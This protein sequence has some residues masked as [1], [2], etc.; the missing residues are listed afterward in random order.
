MFFVSIP[1]FSWI[2]KEVLW[3]A[4]VQSRVSSKKLF[5]GFLMKGRVLS[6][7]RM[8]TWLWAGPFISSGRILTWDSTTVGLSPGPA[9]VRLLRSMFSMP[10]RAGHTS[11]TDDVGRMDRAMTDTNCS[12]DRPQHHC[13]NRRQP[14]AALSTAV[15]YRCSKQMN[16]MSSC[17][18]C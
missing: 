13:K 5:H 3:L 17:Y 18:I 12:P 15:A 16:I 9:E 11:N 6:G 2:V 1:E 8:Q 10:S 4:T 7:G 14:L